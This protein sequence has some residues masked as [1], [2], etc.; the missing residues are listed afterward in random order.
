MRN[1]TKV[2]EAMIGD[3]TRSDIV[4]KMIGSQEIVEYFKHQERK[5][6]EVLLTVDNLQRE[7]FLEDISFTLRRGEVVGLW[8]L[9][10]SGRTELFRALMGLDQTYA[11]HVRV[12]QDGSTVNMNS[13]NAWKMMGYLTEDRRTDG[14]LLPMSIRLNMSLANLRDLLSRFW[15]FVSRSKEERITV[16]YVAKL[17]IKSTSVE[18]VV[19]TLSGGNQQKVVVGR[20]LQTKPSIFLLDEPTR[21][22]DVEAKGELHEIVGDLADSGAAVMV[23]SSDLDEIMSLCDRF[24]VMVR[25]RIVNAFPR[26]VTKNELLA[27][28]SGISLPAEGVN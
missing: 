26:E 17:N 7:G 14:L 28:A 9:L 25:G 20:W 13:R 4:E 5:P 11:G 6:G 3:L 18:Q 22:L 27:A 24:L 10:G 12:H 2:A 23:V 16:D 8:G 21:G 19:R 15:P 1:G